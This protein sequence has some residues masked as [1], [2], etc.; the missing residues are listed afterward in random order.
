MKKIS[1][2]IGLFLLF[3]S[4][5]V[6]LGVNRVQASITLDSH[7]E[8]TEFVNKYQDSPY[9]YSYHDN[10]ATCDDSIML[11]F[12][13]TDSAGIDNANYNGDSMTIL[14]AS[15]YSGS[16]MT[17]LYLLNPDTGN[18]QLR[19]QSVNWQ[20]MSW[21]SQIFCNVD[22]TN[23]FVATST[24]GTLSFNY[25]N[26]AISQG[27]VESGDVIVAS[28]L[29]NATD[30]TVVSPAEM[31]GESY[32]SKGTQT[33]YQTATTTS[34]LMYWNKQWTESKIYTS[35]TLNPVA[36]A[37]TGTGLAITYQNYQADNKQLFLRGTCEQNGSGIGQMEIY[38][39]YSTSTVNLLDI[40]AWN[41]APG[42]VSCYNDTWS[43]YIRG[44][45]LSGTHTIF[46]DDSFYHSTSTPNVVSVEQ[47]F[48]Y[49]PV[50]I[51]A[52][53][54]ILGKTPDELAC[55]D[56]EW[57]DTDWWTQL[58]C[59]SVSAFYSFLNTSQEIV[60]NIVN[61]F[62]GGFVTTFQ[63]IFPF[64]IPVNIYDSW[65]SSAS[66]TLPADM[67]WLDNEIDAEGNIS[68]NIGSAFPTIASTATT[69]LWG[70][71]IGADF[72]AWETWR[73]RV[74]AIIG[75]LIW[76]AFIYFSIYKRAQRIYEDLH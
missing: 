17:T 23:P 13:S 50:P 64:N 48:T 32:W 60:S 5:W 37:P 73:V 31:I 69:T 71:D 55:S 65:T 19:I 14:N 24:V 3:A 36:E 8:M 62:I 33:G 54:T 70:K 39:D 41:S 38:L 7:S 4:L 26:Q 35:V 61:S 27:G 47:N 21:T 57:A 53:S 51:Y 58:R 18:N 25:D 30:M 6:F 67:A 22:Q 10:T 68:I 66:S 34:V 74:R 75:W 49:S 52:T 56:A 16:A 11:V 59:G 28:F 29:D 15:V 20:A 43:T 12:V 1:L 9:M 46:I 44:F 45:P 72:T 40:F 42:Y 63:T 2:K 76:G